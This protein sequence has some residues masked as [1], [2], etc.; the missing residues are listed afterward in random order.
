[1]PL[2][3]TV[4]FGAPLHIQEHETKEAFLGR[5]SSALL[6]LRPQARS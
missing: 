2:I 5:G 3:C 6:A 4:T 1:L